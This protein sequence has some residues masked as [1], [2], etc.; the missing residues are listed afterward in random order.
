VFRFYLIINIPPRHGK[1][2][3]ASRR[4]PIHHLIRNPD[5]EF[6]LGTYAANLSQYIAHSARQCFYEAGRVGV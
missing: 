2:D 4:W 6:I 5:H 1:T 3:L